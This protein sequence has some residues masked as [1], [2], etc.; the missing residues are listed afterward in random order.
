MYPP[1]RAQPRAGPRSVRRACRRPARRPRPRRRHPRPRP[2]PR[3]E[4]VPPPRRRRRSRIRDR[5]RPRLRR[6]RLP[7]PWEFPRR[8]RP[9]PPSPMRDGTPT[10][11]GRPNARTT[12]GRRR[13]CIT[14][15]H[16]NRRAARVT[17]AG[18]ITIAWERS[19][20]RL[21]GGTSIGPA[22]NASGTATRR[23]ADRAAVSCRARGSFSMI[24]I[25]HA[26]ARTC[27]GPW[28]RAQRREGGS[29]RYHRRHIQVA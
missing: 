7:R 21:T 25:S 16:R 17:T 3:F 2:L 6:S 13:G 11:A 8:C 18:R 26:V 27:R 24:P 12:G 23:R 10:W 29:A 20:R 14:G 28:T 1:A 22:A 19:P 5:R 4:L 9:R 15:T